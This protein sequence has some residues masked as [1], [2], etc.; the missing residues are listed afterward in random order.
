[1]LTASY[2]YDSLVVVRLVIIC[3]SHLLPEPSEVLKQIRHLSGVALRCLRAPWSVRQ[4][5]DYLKPTFFGNELHELAE[6]DLESRNLLARHLKLLVVL[7]DFLLAPLV[8]LLQNRHVSLHDLLVAGQLVVH[9]LELVE[10][11][12][13]VYQFVQGVLEAL[14]AFLSAHLPLL[15]DDLLGLLQLLL[16]H[17]DLL[18]VE[19]ILFEHH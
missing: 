5:I 7:L 10:V 1:M 9:D 11:L 17:V 18:L 8:L 2:P 4:A 6:L 15:V 19:L 12:L 16:L 14:A 13:R 3:L